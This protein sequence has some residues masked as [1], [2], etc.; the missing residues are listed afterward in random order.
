M[1]CV[2]HYSLPSD[3]ESYYQ[4]SG[5]AGRDGKFSFA[6]LF[7]SYSDVKIQEY[8]INNQAPDAYHAELVYDKLKKAKEQLTVS[9]LR[10]AYPQ[11]GS[12]NRCR[13]ALFAPLWHD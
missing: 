10:A 11:K 8:F 3:I 6:I 2:I 12:G 13:F 5:R 1:R 9:A 4:E 7:Y